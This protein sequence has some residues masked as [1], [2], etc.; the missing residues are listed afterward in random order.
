MKEIIGK[1]LGCTRV[2]R[3][4][5]DAVSVTVLECGPCSVMRKKTKEKDGYEAYQVAFGKELKARVSPLKGRKKN[6]DGSLPKIERKGRKRTG[7]ASLPISGQFARASMKPR[8]HVREIKLDGTALEIGNE[9]KVD[10]FREGEFVDVSGTSRG[11]G[12]AGSV[13]RHH[14]GG[15]PVTHGQSDRMRAPGSVGQSSFPSRVFKGLRMAGRMGN[16]KVTSLKLQVVKIIA[17][18]N[19]MLVKGSVPG[20]KGSLVRVRSTNR[21]R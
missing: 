2:F 13:K 11:L 10:I 20:H 15:G 9:V 5:G 12:F 3:D 6:D 8:E 7:E 18:E 1:K 21:G 17:D 14:F 4:N 16:E 19:L